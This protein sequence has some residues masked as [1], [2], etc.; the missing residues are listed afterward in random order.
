MSSFVCTAKSLPLMLQAEKPSFRFSGATF[1]LL[2]NA[3]IPSSN[4][5]DPSNMRGENRITMCGIVGLF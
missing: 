1:T 2:E 4:S 3:F 5:L